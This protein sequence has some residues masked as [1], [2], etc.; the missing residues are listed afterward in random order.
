[1]VGK[2]TCREKVFDVCNIVFM[3]L[4]IVVTLYPFY[5]VVVASLSESL[6]L[7]GQEG[8][9]L[10]PVGFSTDAYEMVL[11]NPNILTGYRTTL[12]VVV[13]G[14][15]LN[16][17]LTSVGAYL[18]TR[19]ELP[20]R[21]VMAYMMIFTM[22]FSGGMIPTYLVVYKGLNLGDSLWALILPG[23]ISTYNLIIMRTN[24]AAI[25][26]SLE[27]SAQI[28]GANDFVILFR[29]ILPLSLPII[30]VMVLFYG[31]SHWNAWFN[32]MIYIRTRSKYPLQL[33]LR[34]ILLLNS[35]ES[36]MNDA[37]GSDKYSIGESIKYAT[38][39]VATLPI[40][41][42]YP[43]IQKY[44]VKGIMIGAVKG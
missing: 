9:M 21:N 27:E 32:A 37:T 12:I 22:Y 23:A 26:A 20:I 5:Y 41:L 42:V 15:F 44:F 30:A 1:M 6:N 7:M 36:M 25:P 29:I 24:F 10:W 14:T 13:A 17:L 8:L 31:V 28:D 4:M 35:T 11:S 43:F 39:I 33:I 3:L 18:L 19:K 34:E 38:I 16:I 2:K 40:L